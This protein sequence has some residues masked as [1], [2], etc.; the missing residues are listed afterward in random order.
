[1][2][3]ARLT[4]KAILSQMADQT[5]RA[6]SFFTSQLEQDKKLTYRLTAASLPRFRYRWI[7]ITYEL[8]AKPPKNRWHF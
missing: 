2:L 6:M 3:L 4:L 8:V 5:I 7:V 1:M